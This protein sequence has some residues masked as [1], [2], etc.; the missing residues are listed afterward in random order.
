MLAI[1]MIAYHHINPSILSICSYTLIQFIYCRYYY[2]LRNDATS[3]YYYYY[4][5]QSYIYTYAYKYDIHN[6]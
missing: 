2:Y 3:I 1:P 6:N 5:Q 4:A